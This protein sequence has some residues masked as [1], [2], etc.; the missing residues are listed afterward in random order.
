MLANYNLH[1]IYVRVRDF[2]FLF[3]LVMIPIPKKN[4]F[5]QANMF[6][7]LYVRTQNL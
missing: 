3:L 5:N 2:N 1:T 6:N 7:Y 4:N